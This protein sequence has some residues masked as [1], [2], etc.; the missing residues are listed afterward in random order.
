ML[1]KREPCAHISKKLG[2]NMKKILALCL[3]I[4]FTQ[5]VFAVPIST[6]VAEQQS[7]LELRTLLDRTTTLS[8]KFIQQLTDNQGE[9]LDT[10]EGTFVLQRPGKFYWK[11]TTPYEQLLVSNQQTIW[12]FDPDLEQVTVRPFS[13]DLQQTPALL[14][15]ESVE[16]LSENFT[17]SFTRANNKTEFTL[18][19]KRDDGLFAQMQLIFAG[20][21]LQD[22]VIQDNLGQ[23]T[24]FS[25]QETVKNKPVD[26][27]LFNFV[28]PEGV[29]V[30]HD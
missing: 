25:L 17:V 28:A 10:S 15:S 8:G 5:S 22:F 11:T 3:L 27:T 9:V 16:R 18:V 19:P 14:L 1:L 23:L 2:K 13:D 7:A 12:L 26:Q 21:E 24:R 30:L 29:D 6:Q 20:E 4:S